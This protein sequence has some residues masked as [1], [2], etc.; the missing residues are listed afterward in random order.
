[1]KL[2]NLKKAILI[3]FSAM[4]TGNIAHANLGETYQESVDRYGQPHNLTSDGATRWVLD[5]DHTVIARFNADNHCDFIEYN[6]FSGQMPDDLLTKISQNVALGDFYQEIKVPV[7]RFWVTKS[8][9]VVACL[10]TGDNH[11]KGRDPISLDIA[12]REAVEAEQASSAKPA[13]T[14]VPRTNT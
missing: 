6:D 14:P 3:A 10:T 1:V 2:N 12:T 9:S 7:G 13:S 5:R 11:G 4:V 8:G